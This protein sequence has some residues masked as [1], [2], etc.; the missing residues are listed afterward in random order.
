SLKHLC[1]STG[2]MHKLPNF[3]REHVQELDLGLIWARYPNSTYADKTKVLD[4]LRYWDHVLRKYLAG[5]S[6]EGDI[7]PDQ[8]QAFLQ[9]VINMQIRTRELVNFILKQQGIKETLLQANT[10][11]D[12]Q[13]EQLYQ[14]FQEKTYSYV[15]RSLNS[16]KPLVSLMIEAGLRCESLVQ[17]YA[18]LDRLPYGNPLVYI[19]EAQVHIN[20]IALSIQMAAQ[21]P[22]SHLKAWFDR[23]VLNQ[24]WIY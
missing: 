21:F 17:K 13:L 5:Q 10:E 9:Y 20:R 1:Q 15:N 7:T 4:W 23:N 6:V 8:I 12:R 24:Q 18:K 22:E 2:L 16:N 3:L 14:R 19:K 11:K